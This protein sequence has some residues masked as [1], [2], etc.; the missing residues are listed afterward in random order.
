MTTGILYK[1]R[2]LKSHSTSK[3]ADVVKT[4]LHLSK[5][6]NDNDY[7]NNNKSEHVNIKKNK[8]PRLT[9]KHNNVEKLKLWRRNVL[10]KMHIAMWQPALDTLVKK[11]ISFAMRCKRGATKQECK[12]KLLLKRDKSN[13][14]HKNLKLGKNNLTMSINQTKSNMRLT[15]LQIKNALTI[16]KQTMKSIA[17]ASSSSQCQSSLEASIPKNISHGH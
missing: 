17:M 12:K 14:L 8:M 13:N 5:H 4:K 7:A 11:R 10:Y 1:T 16:G 15:I 9:A 3:K 2:V 6:K